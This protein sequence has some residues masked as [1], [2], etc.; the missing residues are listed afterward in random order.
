MAHLRRV[1]VFCGSNAGARPEYC[2]AAQA[3]GRDVTRDEQFEQSQDAACRALDAHN[4]R[5][6]NIEGE[7]GA[8]VYPSMKFLKAWNMRGENVA[9]G[10][11]GV[12]GGG[13][14]AI[15]TARVALRQQGVD[16]VTILYRRTREEM[17]AFEPEIQAALRE[18]ARLETLV[19]PIK[20]HAEEGHIT[21][22]EL[23]RN[24]LGEP[25][26]SGRR[27]PV[28]VE[29]SEFTVEL[30]T[31]IVA[32]GEQLQPFELSGSAGVEITSWGTMTVDRDTLA[33]SRDGVFAGGDVVTGPN[34]VVDAIAAGKKAARVIDRYIH[35]QEL[36]RPARPRR[37]SV[38]VPPAEAVEAGQA[39]ADCPTVP[40]EER[41]A[42]F[43]EV[44]R[45]LAVEEARREAARCLRCDLEFTQPGEQPAREQL[46]SSGGQP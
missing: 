42:S 16:S 14:S 31:L 39:R 41:R 33:T 46:Q 23:L 24:Q 25:D 9:R 18:G 12:I 5:R 8:G 19:T 36:V 44:E 29:G 34:T 21:A 32:I 15:D 38:H 17:P 3:M 28:P 26:M 27:R 20:I 13:N 40:V 11:V 45:T 6:L 2:H 10:R 1:C 7:D 37:P 43:V 4:S 30:D 22:V 35:R